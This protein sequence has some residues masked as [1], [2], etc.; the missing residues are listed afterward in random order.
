M[1]SPN[2]AAAE[3]VLTHKTY[4]RS[5]PDCHFYNFFSFTIYFVVIYITDY[6]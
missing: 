3:R 5:G 2:S 4:E 6:V 1:E